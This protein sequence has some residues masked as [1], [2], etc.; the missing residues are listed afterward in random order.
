M[1]AF[2]SSWIILAILV[3]GAVSMAKRR[4]PGTPITWGQALLAGTFAFFVMFW[5][6]GVVPDMWLKMADNEFKWRPDN[7]FVGPMDIF[8]PVSKGGAWFPIIVSYQTLRD[9]IVVGIYVALLGAQM[10]VWAWWQKRGTKPS[11]EIVTSDYGRPLV[12]KA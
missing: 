8:E 11:T 4:P 7:L 2:I 6:Y 12:K 9:L 10:S 3:G 5:A 1:V